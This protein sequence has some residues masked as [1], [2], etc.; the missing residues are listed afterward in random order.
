MQHATSGSDAN[1]KYIEELKKQFLKLQLNYVGT[2]KENFLKSEFIMSDSVIMEAYVDYLTN[3][4]I[5]D[6]YMNISDQDINQQ[7]ESYGVT[8]TEI[9]NYWNDKTGTF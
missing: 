4:T 5:E 6:N 3:L 7:I 1:T 2:S 9:D 8:D